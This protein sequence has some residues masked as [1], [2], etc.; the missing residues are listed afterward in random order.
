MTEDEHRDCKIEYIADVVTTGAHLLCWKAGLRTLPRGGRIVLNLD[1]CWCP[2]PHIIST[3]DDAPDLLRMRVLGRSVYCPVHD[4]HF[5]VRQLLDILPL[6]KRKTTA[7]KDKLLATIPWNPEPTRFY[8]F[9]SGEDYEVTA[10][11]ADPIQAL[12]EVHPS[13]KQLLRGMVIEVASKQR[14]RE[15]LKSDTELPWKTLTLRSDL[16]LEPL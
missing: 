2:E 7:K 16:T 4:A 11:D 3:D 8:V 12:S 9:Q 10:I 1:R 13:P 5:N 15:I 6:G 14:A